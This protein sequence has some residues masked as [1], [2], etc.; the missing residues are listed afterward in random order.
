MW[1]RNQQNQ[2][3]ARLI[4]QRK[5][6]DGVAAAPRIPFIRRPTRRYRNGSAGHEMTAG[7]SYWVSVKGI[8][9]LSATP[10]ESR[11]MKTTV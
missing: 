3:I 10:E 8:G 9:A 6:C 2:R 5:R 4:S 11:A 7:A 1:H